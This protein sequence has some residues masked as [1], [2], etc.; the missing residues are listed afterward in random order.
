[1]TSDDSNIINDEI[2]I[3]IATLSVECNEW[4]YITDNEYII[5]SICPNDQ[6]SQ[7]IIGCFYENVPFKNKNHF[8]KGKK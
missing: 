1:M 5:K 2:K 3:I 4:I 7:D 8:M 6:C